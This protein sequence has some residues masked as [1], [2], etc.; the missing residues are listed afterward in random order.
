MLDFFFTKSFNSSKCRTLLKLTIPRIK[1]LRNRREIQVKQMRGEI[2]KLLETDQEASA[3]I[4]VENILRE[5][6]MM[7]AHEL[8]ELFCELITARLPIID[9]QKECPL[10][11]KEA[12]SSVCFA[13]PRCADLPELH[14]VQTLFS[15]K[16]GKEFV[17]SA[18]ELLPECGVNRQLV[19]LLSVRAPS[20]DV[21]LKMLKEIAKEHELDWDPS[22]SENDLLKTRDDLLDGPIQ[23]VSDPR[24]RAPFTDAHNDEDFDEDFEMIDFPEVPMQQPSQSDKD[25]NEEANITLDKVNRSQ[26]ELGAGLGLTPKTEEDVKVS[27][28]QAQDK[29]FVPFIHPPPSQLPEPFPVEENGSSPSATKTIDDKADFQDVLAAAEAAAETAEGA[30]AAARSACSLAELRITELMKKENEDF[31]YS[32]SENPF[33]LDKTKTVLKE[34]V[35]LDAINPFAHSNT[36]F[37]SPGRNS[38]SGHSS[39]DVKGVFDSY[40]ESDNAFSYSSLNRN[41]PLSPMDDDNLDFSYPNLF[42]SQGS[43]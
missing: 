24:P 25:M 37:A 36:P 34:E 22:A 1:L 4:R 11:L 20:P 33:H 39:D 14:Q 19:D 40:S 29:Q 32:E 2:A 17:S 43:K 27:T 41:T 3:R 30:A 18:A 16:Y 38:A 7:A 21:K 42:T 15:G 8:V 35:E 9:A 6:K 5:E 10:D 23:F 28:R 12:I 13:A 26:L 31:S